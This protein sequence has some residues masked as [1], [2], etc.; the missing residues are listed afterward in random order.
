VKRSKAHPNGVLLYRIN[1]RGKSVVYATDVEQKD[2]GYPI[3][4]VLSAAP[5][6]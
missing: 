5:T 6:C 4:F 3:S 1:Y 2:G